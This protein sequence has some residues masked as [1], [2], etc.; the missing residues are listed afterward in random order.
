[1][2]RLAGTKATGTGGHLLVE[3]LKAAG[4]KHLFANP[5]SA[6][7]GLFD[8]LVDAPQIKLVLGLHEGVVASMADGY[9][10]ASGQVAV[11]NVHAVAGTAQMGGQLYNSARDCSSV[12]VTAG[13]LDNEYYT[14][15]MGLSASTGFTQKEVV[16]Q[17]TKMAWE[18][19]NPEAIPL[20][21][22]R[23][24]KVATT[25]PFGP[26]YVAYASY[27][28]QA[29]N[30]TATIYPR[31][32][33]TVPDTACPSP[34]AIESAADML[35]QC[36]FP[37][38]F[39]GDEVWQSGAQAELLELV[40]WLGAAVTIGYDAFK[41]FPVHHPN[42]MNWHR[43]AKLP[44]QTD[45]CVSVAGRVIGGWGERET[46]ASW[47]I[48][49]KQIAIGMDT[50]HLGRNYPVDLAIAANVKL[51]LQNLLAA[52]KDRVPESKMKPI[53]DARN[54]ELARRSSAVRAEDQA[55]LKAAFA[56]KPIQPVRLSYEF[57]RALPAGTIIVNENYTAD[58]SPISFGFRQAHN[59]KR[60]LGISGA[61]LGWS[62]GAAIGAKIA[63][64]DTPVVVS[65]G[66]GSVMFS[67]S[68]FWTMKRYGVPLLVVVWNNLNYQTV[69][70][71]FHRMNARS[72]QTGHY[73]G[74]YLGQPDIDFVMLARSQGVGG[75]RV[76]EPED[77]AAALQRGLDANSRG[78]PYLLDVVV[79]RTGGGA[80]STWY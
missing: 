53:R 3:Q 8:A 6:E 26:T 37:V 5:G 43:H 59:E 35:A 14:D 61:S 12:V 41:S 64:P 51:T 58:H 60:Y 4:V 19:R 2:G 52:L 9:N 40:E 75:E 78:E 65:I 29:Q 28:L 57:E 56:G 16:R 38:L 46:E 79:A 69:R 30:I 11:V 23:A 24:I 31:D 33:F 74:I 67:S 66:D 42:F 54:E 72:A 18:I 48:Y 39:V 49:D 34:E 36:R 32:Q 7:G 10:K 73:P 22:R 21:T 20:A 44:P 77:I 47:P 45:L 17:F 25:A 76:T 27:A 15:L 70:Y 71:V 50:E 63:C 62:L 68:A 13:L 80:D 1:M 55:R